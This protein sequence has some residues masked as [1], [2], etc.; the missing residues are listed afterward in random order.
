VNDLVFS[1]MLDGQIVA[2]DRT[3]GK[4]VWKTKAPGGI[5]GWMSA[6][7]DQLVVPVGNAQPSQVVA[8]RVGS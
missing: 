8:Y 4:I 1:A 6:A 5:N 3:S 7:G 2:I